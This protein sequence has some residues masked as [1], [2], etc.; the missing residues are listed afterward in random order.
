[1][2]HSIIQLSHMINAPYDVPVSMRHV[3][4]EFKQSPR[5]NNN[6]RLLVSFFVFIWI[7]ATA[8]GV[9]ALAHYSYKASVSPA[10]VDWPCDSEIERDASGHVLLIFVHPKCV[11]S[12]ASLTQL[13]RICSQPTNLC[14]VTTVFY[15]PTGQLPSWSQTQLWTEADRLVECDRFIDLGGK[16]ARRFGVNTSGHVLLFDR[17]GQRIY[18]GGITSSRG[19]YGSNSSSDSVVQLLQ[20]KKPER[21]ESPVF[22]CLMLNDSNPTAVTEDRHG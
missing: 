2:Q 20:N 14:A 5:V 8:M 15:C 21:S 10:V 22:G 7:S 4:P 19:H 3:T 11:C 18:S 1:M 9:L 13:A 17:N 12:R 6:R 16:E